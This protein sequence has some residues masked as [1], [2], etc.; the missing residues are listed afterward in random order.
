MATA[1]LSGC[2]VE[3][4][5]TYAAPERTPPRLSLN[6]TQPPLDQIYVTQVGAKINFSI[7]VAAEDDGVSLQGFLLVDFDGT[8][9]FSAWELGMTLPPSTL[10]DT[11]RKLEFSRQI[12][13]TFAPGDYLGCHRVTLRVSHISNFNINAPP[14]VFDR[15]DVAE[16]YW[17]LN[18]IDP[19][20]GQDGSVLVDCPRASAEEP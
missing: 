12:T 17:W 16:A 11:T 7:P 6:Q 1:M 13:K 18:V 9:P 3:D 2:L 5:P 20:K 10:D 19:A 8:L 15:T 14:D 4:P